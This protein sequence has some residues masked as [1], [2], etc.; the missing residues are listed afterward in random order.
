[1][2]ISRGERVPV[3]LL[4]FSAQHCT[5]LWQYVLPLLLPEKFTN[6]WSEREAQ[7]SDLSNLRGRMNRTKKITGTCQ[8]C[9]NPFLFLAEAIGGTSTC[10]HC[11]KET[12]LILATPSH[13]PIV[14]RRMIVYGAITVL[15]LVLG[16]FACIYALK[17]AQ[18]LTGAPKKQPASQT[19]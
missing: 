5:L 6:W 2:L 9:G 14:P 18:N 12:E 4:A 1:L 3:R 17:R 15:I 10:P 13:E 11:G 8:H 7:P 16:L 19:Q